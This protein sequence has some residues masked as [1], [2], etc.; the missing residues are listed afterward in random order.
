MNSP[1]PCEIALLP[2]TTVDVAVTFSSA[3]KTVVNVTSNNPKLLSRAGS[4]SLNAYSF[5]SMYACKVP[6]SV[7]QV[8]TKPT[9]VTLTFKTVDG[10]NLTCKIPLKLVP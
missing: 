9:N 10:T 6:F 7:N 2:W 8:V 3:V 1:A 4:L 5:G